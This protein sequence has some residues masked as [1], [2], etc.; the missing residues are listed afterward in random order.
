M[1]RASARSVRSETSLEPIPVARP[2]NTGSGPDRPRCGRRD[3]RRSKLVVLLS[4]L[5]RVVGTVGF[6]EDVRA[7][8][9]RLWMRLRLIQLADDLPHIDVGTT[10]RTASI[11]RPSWTLISAM[12]MLLSWTR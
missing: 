5:R 10:E 6:V 9:D 12:S 1:H 8:V 7:D 3:G 11:I 4:E 2:D